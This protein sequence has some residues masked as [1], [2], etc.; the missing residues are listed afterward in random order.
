MTTADFYDGYHQKNHAF[1]GVISEN[2]ATYFYIQQTLQQAC[3][4][5]PSKTWNNT[6]VLDV[7]CGVGALSL[8]LASKGAQVD[9]IDISPRAVTIA[10]QAADSLPLTDKLSFQ[11]KELSKAKT[12]K[13][14]FVLCSEV[15]EH[16]PDDQDFYARLI[17][18]LKPRGVLMLTTPSKDNALYRMGYYRDFDQEVGH[19]RRY[20]V[21]SLQD[22][23][24]TQSVAIH[25]IKAVEGPLRNILFTSKL[26]FLVKFLK[27][28]I[29]PTFH[30]F[31]RISAR[32]L[33]ASD[34]QALVIKQST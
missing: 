4:L 28:P 21:D 30:F 24:T 34:L 20:T 16:V 5:L 12:G 18:Q 31:D 26:G 32:L 25:S 13:Y 3:T 11:K 33:G 23:L 29:N 1:S 27:G 14:D 9:G 22:L 2:N 19:L 8:Y 10:Q 15:I 6:K 17:S 7:G